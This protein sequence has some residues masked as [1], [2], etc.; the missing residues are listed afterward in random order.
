MSRRPTLTFGRPLL[1]SVERGPAPHVLRGGA[2]LCLMLLLREG[3]MTAG[4]FDDP[5]RLLLRQL[6]LFNSFA[7]A[8]A[9]LAGSASAMNSVRDQSEPA[10][11]LSADSG[12][13]F[14]INRLLPT[15]AGLLLL[16][17]MQLPL[18][19]YFQML[20]GVTTSD[21]LGITVGLCGWLAVTTGIG[22]WLGAA[23]LGVIGTFVVFTIGYVGVLLVAIMFIKVR[24]VGPVFGLTFPGSPLTASLMLAAI[25][26]AVAVALLR[27]AGRIVLAPKVIPLPVGVPLF[28]SWPTPNSRSVPR[29]S[30]VAPPHSL[31]GRPG[32]NPHWWKAFHVANDGVDSIVARVMT[33]GGFAVCCSALQWS[34]TAGTATAAIILLSLDAALLAAR[35]VRL[36]LEADASL[37]ELTPG[38]FQK[39]ADGVRAG[40]M[41]FLMPAAVVLAAA[42]LVR[43]FVNGPTGNMTVPGLYVRP[44]VEVALAT[45]FSAVVGGMAA[46]R[47]SAGRSV[48][49]AILAHGVVFFLGMVLGRSWFAIA[50]KLGDWI[51][52]MP[53]VRTV[54]VILGILVLTLFGPRDLMMRRLIFGRSWLP[55]ERGGPAA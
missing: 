16:I 5:G 20:G 15:A 25:E 40:S 23:G 36:E 11:L 29:V 10:L 44:L 32:K 1:A 42:M 18:I 54:L 27:T 19:V 33:L 7:I 52:L 13:R 9:A 31:R 50:S 8:V 53:G 28:K 48:A 41:V 39:A 37:L 17:L 4:W 51:A 34:L 14:A 45:K 12:L 26:V 22:G 43:L 3:L 24:I 6:V 38:G 55:W 30:T 46:L 35:R 47:F 21:V 2:L 49:I